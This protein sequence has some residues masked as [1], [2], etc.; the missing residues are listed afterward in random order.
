MKKRFLAL[1]LA[2]CMLVSFAGCGG[3]GGS[4][5]A[6]GD[7]SSTTENSAAGTEN[8]SVAEVDETKYPGLTEQEKEAVSLGL[9]NLDGTM[10][11]IPDPDAFEEKYGK[12]SMFVHYTGSRTRPVT[13]LAMVKEW[14]ELTGI[15]F[16]W[17]DVPYDGV[18]EKINLTLSAGGDQLPDC[19][20]NFVDGQSSNFVVQY[21]D[22][23][24]FMP[25]EDIIDNYMP[26]YKALLES[27]EEYRKI[28]TAPDGHIYGFPYIEEMEG[29]VLTPGP[30]VINNDWLGQVNM[31][32]PTTVD[33]YVE[34]LKAFRDAGDLNGNGQADETPLAVQFG[35]HDTFGSNDLFYRFTGCFGQADSYCG[36]NNYADHLYLNE[37]GKVAFSATDEAFRKTAE[38]FNMLWNEGLIW[39]G[40]FEADTSLAFE[41][42]LLKQDV[43]TVGSYSTWGGKESITNI[44]VRNQ[45][46]ALPRLEGE[47]GK[48][49]F[50]L[51]YSELQDSS[52]TAITTN[53]EFPHVI[54][55][56]VEAI[57][58][59]PKLAVTSNWGAV[60]AVFVEEED[61]FL[62]KPRDENGNALPQGEFAD[63]KESARENTTPCRGSFIIKD[64]YYEDVCDYDAVPL[65]E[66]QKTNGKEEML[67]EYADSVLPRT[68]LTVEESSRVSQIQPTISD[69]V[70]RYVVDWVLNGVT[71]ESWQSYQTELENAGVADLISI[72]QAAID[73]YNAA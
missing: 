59:D 71:D 20:W 48:T 29:L 14:E 41:N 22:Q 1:A 19:F 3:N 58:S 30:F 43:A 6:S 23:G 47:N 2:L 12:I 39:N 68:M 15:R 51:N 9:I 21:A 36:G 61:G 33:E 53:C 26:N 52:N 69:I 49:G 64:S 45:Y 25:T 54:G 34:V 38:F 31:D 27:K 70:D 16:E 10:P 4:S 57:S 11:I 67:E 50:R 72:W 32:M 44:E 13:E 56:M 24:V 60:G 8:S 65:L 66:G 63:G 7:G 55:L 40:S 35:A 46:E 73:R 5:V 42:S 28:A 62:T 18:A 17:Q 37:E